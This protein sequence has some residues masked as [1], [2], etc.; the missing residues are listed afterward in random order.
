MGCNIFA[1]DSPENKIQIVQALKANKQVCSMT[2]DGVN[3]APALRAANIGAAMGITGTDVSKEAAKIVLADDNFATI[4]LAVREGRRVWD[5]LRKILRVFQGNSSA[6]YC[7]LFMMLAQIFLVYVPKVNEF[8]PMEPMDGSQWGTVFLFTFALFFIVEF[9][10][11]FTNQ[12]FREYIRPTMRKIEYTFCCLKCI[13]CVQCGKSTTGKDLPKDLE[14]V[15]EHAKEKAEHEKS[16]PQI[17]ASSSATAAAATT[18]ST[19]T[20]NNVVNV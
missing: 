11:W 3:D 9:E 4:E 1:Q 10:K 20:T 14:A 18:P 12:Y 6:I 16:N 15:V 17:D 8:F 19:T 5:N 2:G 13:S 7:S